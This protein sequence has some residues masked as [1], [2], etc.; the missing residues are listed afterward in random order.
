MSTRL[1]SAAQLRRRAQRGLSLIEL[2][3]FIAVIGIA[4]AGV[5]SV[6]GNTVRYSVDPMV[7]KQAVAIAESLLTEVLAQ[8]FTYCDPQDTANNLSPPPAST[9][10]CTGGAINSEDNAGG[11]LGPRPAT[12]T[13]F[14]ATNPF[15]NVA[16]YAG[17]AMAAGIFSLDDGATPIAGL[18]D[19]AATV[20]ITRAGIVF[21]LAN[22]AVLRVDV[23]VTGRGEDIPL[24]GYRFRYAPN[25]T[26]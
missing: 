16:D 17:Y 25:A 3:I 7:R 5:L 4:I 1:P 13:R 9:A 22:D 15:D 23:R 6:Y 11:V 18:G 14:L 20:T 8:P 21:G 12:E 26:G 10:A 2:V 24:T 19:Y